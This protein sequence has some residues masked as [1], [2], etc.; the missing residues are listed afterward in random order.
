[1]TNPLHRDLESLAWAFLPY[2]SDYVLSGAHNRERPTSMFS[3]H[4]LFT[5]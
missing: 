3:R 5:D 2:A 1:M 4:G